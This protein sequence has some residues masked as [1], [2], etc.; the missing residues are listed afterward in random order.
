MKP[1]YACNSAD[2]LVSRRRF[3]AGAAG[4]VGTA[5]L[6]GFRGMVEPA[7]ANTLRRAERRV[8]VIWMA[9]GVSQLETWDPKPGT[10]TGGPFQSIATNVAGTRI[11]ELLPYTAR[12]MDRLALV[13]G[14]NTATDDHGLGTYIMHTGR[15]RTPGEEFPH[16]G[17]VAA[18]LLGREENPLPGYI[19]I[20][21]RGDGGTNRQDAAFLGPRFAS[22]A[23]ADGNPP[24]NT[25]RPTDVSEAADRQRNQ[26]RERLNGR[27]QLGRRTAET[28]AY[29]HSYDQAAQLMQRRA[30][31]DISRESPRDRDR[32]GSH[33]FGRHL[34]LARRLLENGLTFVKVTHSNYDTH[35][36]NFDFHIEQIGEFD[37]PFSC[38]I[39]DLVQRGLWESTLVV[40]MSEFGRTPNIN[41]NMGRDHWSR[42]WSVALG[43]CGIRGGAVAGATNANG[44][45]VTE[46]QVNGGHLFHTYFKALGLD[47][48]RN[49]YH[50]G[51]P[52]PMADP[53]T[54]PIDEILTRA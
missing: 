29:T 26:L 10:N 44:T 11:S 12:H 6:L 20:T 30:V 49:H 32:Y 23:L 3:L 19:H 40:V 9:G 53:Q 24:A 2:H 35:H 13:R 1:F 28:E 42:A 45:A 52:I 34:L 4:A 41:R 46:R 37:R 16:L 27:F 14:I 15:R 17:S 5:G 43:G 22:V 39:E 33:D 8:L 31:F 54:S 48:R 51:R 21:P 36:E 18:K 38:L 47:G 50:N 25:L 7:A